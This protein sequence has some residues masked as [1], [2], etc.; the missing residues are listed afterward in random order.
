MIAVFVQHLQLNYTMPVHDSLTRHVCLIK[1]V[2][3]MI[4][5]HLTDEHAVN[6]EEYLI[7]VRY[8]LHWDSVFYWESFDSEHVK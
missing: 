6:S 2:S 3:Y 4:K 7:S 8:T 5:L 1:G